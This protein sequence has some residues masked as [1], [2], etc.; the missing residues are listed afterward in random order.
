MRSRSEPEPYASAREDDDFQ[1]DSVSDLQVLVRRAVDAGG[2]E[3]FRPFQ[4]DEAR[5][6]GHVLFEPD[7]RARP[8][9]GEREQLALLR[10]FDPLQ[11]IGVA[12]RAHDPRLPVDGPALRALRRRQPPLPEVLEER[13]DAGELRGLE[14]VEVEG[15]R[16]GKVHER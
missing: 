8:Y 15:E 4:A 1:P 12:L 9:L 14:R 13:V 10:E 7:W 3:D 2:K 11:G 6:E 16:E 5:H